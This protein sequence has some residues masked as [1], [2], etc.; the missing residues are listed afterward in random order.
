MS[1]AETCAVAMRKDGVVG[2]LCVDGQG[3]C[4]HSEGQV[5]EGCNGSVAEMAARSLTLVGDGAVVTAEG[6]TGKVLISR[7]DGATIALFM[8]AK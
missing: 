2:V 1:F 3:L 7:C 4:L 8:S 5:P 6:P